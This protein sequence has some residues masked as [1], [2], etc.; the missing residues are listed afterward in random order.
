M[1]ETF[2]TLSWLTYHI[3]RDQHSEKNTQHMSQS[4]SATL[5]VINTAV[6][7]PTYHWSCAMQKQ[8]THFKDRMQGQSLAT[9]PPIQLEE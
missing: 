2:Q 9:N 6:L 8:F 7:V 4:H 5:N 1:L 3:T